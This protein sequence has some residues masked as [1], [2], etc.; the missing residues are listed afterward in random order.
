[1]GSSPSVAARPSRA[2]S[3]YPRRCCCSCGSWPRARSSSPVRPGS[4]PGARVGRG[5]HHLPAQALDHSFREALGT[6]YAG[7]LHVVPRL[8]AE[9][10]ALLPLSAAAAVVAIDSASVASLLAAYVWVA[11]RTVFETRARACA[12]RSAVPV[13]AADVTELGGYRR[14]PPL[15]RAARL[16]LRVHA[17]AGEPARDR[18][19]AAVV[20]L[21]ALSD[22]LLA[23]LLPFV[24]LRPGAC[25]RTS[26]RGDPR[27][28][29]AAGRPGG[30]GADL[31]WP[32]ERFRLLAARA[33][34]DLCPARRR[35]R[36]AGRLVVRAAVALGGLGRG[37][38]RARDRG[39]GARGA[40]VPG[41]AARRQRRHALLAA[42]GS[43][44]LF[45]VPLGDPRHDREAPSPGP[46]VHGRRALHVLAAGSSP[47]CR[48]LLLVD[49]RGAW[50]ARGSPRS[51][52]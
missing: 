12:A 28:R 6:T 7:Y 18:R 51:W 52:W 21:T 34:D 24:V 1:M 14:E 36:G 49:R 42:A 25:K 15:V 8:L 35:P 37:V 16:V 27:R 3:A 45:S 40:R 50:A 46:P 44:V 20:G 22:P 19:G 2:R 48:A 17:Q 26:A 30:G 33:A 11:S 23:L 39:P 31:L 43:L 47:G 9:P 38:G 4:P 10:A 5:R 32:R 41:P 13:R 29:A